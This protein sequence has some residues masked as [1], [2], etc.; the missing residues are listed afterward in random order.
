MQNI[1]S[2]KHLRIPNDI[3]KGHQLGFHSTYSGTNTSYYYINTVVQT[4][5]LGKNFLSLSQLVS[6]VYSHY[7]LLYY[8]F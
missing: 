4:L 7:L 8:M 3:I 5:G 1:C 6:L 2:I